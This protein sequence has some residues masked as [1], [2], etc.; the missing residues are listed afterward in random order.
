MHILDTICRSKRLEIA[1]QKE[2]VP[3]SEL[4]EILHSQRGL[5]V[6]SAMTNA[7]REKISFKQALAH[8]RS[9]IIAEFKR[10]SPAKGWIYPDADVAKV[11]QSYEAAGAAAISCLTDEPFF[12]GSF[13]DFEKAR[14]TVRQIPLLRK[15]FILDEYQIYQS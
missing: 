2:A 8:S 10:K 12:G 4:K 11:V 14:E 7:N 13:T 3:L 1:R 6:K 15:D 5:Q 9:G